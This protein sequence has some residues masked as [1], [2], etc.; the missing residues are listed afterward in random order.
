VAAYAPGRITR[1]QRAQLLHGIYVI[2]NDEPRALDLARDA[3]AAGVRIVQ[4][5]A[6]NGINPERIRTLRALTRDHDALLVM[7][8]DWRA[9]CEFD[10]DGVHLGPDDDGFARAAEVR[11]AIGER[12]VGLS[13]GTLREVRAA[14][15]AGADYLGIGSVFA[16]GSKADAGA[17]IG[18]GG[19][20]VLAS[21]SAAPVAAIG[22]ITAA[23]ISSVRSCG[24]AMAAVISAISDAA[25]PRSGAGTLVAAWNEGATT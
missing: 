17:P 19:L 15:A 8:D 6:K 2:V 7:N 24:A 3:L 14:N 9:A 18:L 10:C 20:R 13:C 12:L 11:A 16:T 1:A 25:D 21:V 22:G 5:R 23:T 4:Y